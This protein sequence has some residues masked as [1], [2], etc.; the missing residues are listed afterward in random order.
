MVWTVRA[1]ITCPAD[2]DGHL[3]IVRCRT[4]DHRSATPD[5]HTMAVGYGHL[6]LCHGGA[7]D[8]DG[9][10][11][12]SH[13]PQK[14]VAGRGGTFWRVLNRARLRSRSEP[15]HLWS[16]DAG[17]RRRNAGTVDTV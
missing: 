4:G 16:S 11:W 1:L 14:G 9:Q 10:S 6:Q 2:L 17:D 5:V 15:A 8:H 12:R 7:V 13:R 3:V